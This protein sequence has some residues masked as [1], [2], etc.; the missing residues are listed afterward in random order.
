MP[1]APMICSFARNGIA[2]HTSGAL[3]PSVTDGHKE[4]GRG[5]ENRSSSSCVLLSES[6]TALGHVRRLRG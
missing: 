3:M 2:S 4:R 5:S 1:M 6:W